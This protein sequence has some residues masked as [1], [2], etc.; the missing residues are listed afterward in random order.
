MNV[1]ENKTNYLRLGFFL[2]REKRNSN[3]KKFKNDFVAVLVTFGRERLSNVAD[4]LT[5]LFPL[6][7]NGL[8]VGS[9]VFTCRRHKAILT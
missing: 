9:R 5:N 8:I 3:F 4:E 6:I 2:D 1:L 7:K